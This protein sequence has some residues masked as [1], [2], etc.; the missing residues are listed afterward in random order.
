M[1]IQVVIMHRKAGILGQKNEQ[2]HRT[3]KR[4]KRIMFQNKNVTILQ[5]YIHFGYNVLLDCSL[6][7]TIT[8]LMNP[9]F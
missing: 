8:I 9:F 5:N 6:C 7:R 4:I 2:K 3:E 1:L